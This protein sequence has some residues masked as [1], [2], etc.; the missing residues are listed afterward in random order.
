MPAME[1]S[2]R[3]FLQT[4][5]A[6]TVVGLPGQKAAP[7][8]TALTAADVIQRIKEKV[9]MPW[10]AQTVDNVVAGRPDVRVRGIATTM[11]STLD[12]VQ[13]ASAAGLN[14]IVTHEPT[15]YTHQ[16]TTEALKTDL[17]YQ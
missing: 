2:R 7:P 12:V 8:Q 10:R 9:A 6:F 17:T 4:S 11:M 13:R 15:F 1:I 16:D 3:H 14:L 5:A